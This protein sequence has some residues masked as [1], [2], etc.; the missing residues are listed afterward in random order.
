MNK[1]LKEFKNSKL[2]IIIILCIWIVFLIFL[3]GCSKPVKYEY[4]NYLIINDTITSSLFYAR[5]YELTNTIN[6]KPENG[7]IVLTKK[8]DSIHKGYMVINGK[9]YHI[10]SVVCVYDFNERIKGYSHGQM[11][12]NTCPPNFNYINFELKFNLPK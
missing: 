8:H 11:I 9:G 10:D 5:Y 2:A 3:F 12:R 7:I 1:I 6:L 4:T